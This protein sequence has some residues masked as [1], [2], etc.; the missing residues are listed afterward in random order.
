MDLS[1]FNQQEETVKKHYEN[2]QDIRKEILTS[3]STLQADFTSKFADVEKKI[4]EVSKTATNDSELM[5]KVHA[6]E[7]QIKELETK[8]ESKSHD[9]EHKQRVLDM[10]KVQNQGFNLKLVKLIEDKDAQVK[11]L[12]EK[13]DS[14]FEQMLKA[15]SEVTVQQ[16]VEKPGGDKINE[17]SEPTQQPKASETT[18]ESDPK[19]PPPKQTPITRSIP[20]RPIIKGVVINPA[21]GSSL[22]SKPNEPEV[23]GKGKEIDTTESKKTKPLPNT[24]KDEELARKIEE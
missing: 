17:Q 19:E 6:Q 21:E 10:Y 20:K 18:K 1:G 7:V 9:A 23:S 4:D 22:T 16:S 12:S 3:I 8:L 24:E 13:I 2:N 5:A 11:N 14:K 15:I